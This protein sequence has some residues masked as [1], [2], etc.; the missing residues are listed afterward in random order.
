MGAGIRTPRSI[1]RQ[2]I[3]AMVTFFRPPGLKLDP[4]WPG[5]GPAT[6]FLSLKTKRK[7]LEN[8]TE[9]EAKTK[10]KRHKTAVFNA[11]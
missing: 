8:E 9:T 6:S 7:L 1:F 4:P 3:F 2:W 5:T 10:R 11:F